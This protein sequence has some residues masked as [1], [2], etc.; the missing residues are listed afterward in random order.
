LTK[1]IS[2]AKNIK[3]RENRQLV[4]RLLRMIQTYFKDTKI[5]N[6]ILYA[7]I[8]EYNVEIFKTFTPEIKLKQFYYRCSNKFV[9][10]RFLHL[11][12]KVLGFIIFING[13]KCNIYKFDN[14]FIKLKSIN[15]NLIKKQRKGGQS[16]LRFS[17]LAKE[18]KHEYIIHVIDHINSLCRDQN[19][20]CYIFGSKELIKMILDRNE[21]LVKL[22]NGGFLN[23]NEDTINES[24]KWLNYLKQK[25]FDDKKLK[26]IVEYLDTNIDMLDFDENNK[27]MMKYYMYKKDL[28]KYTK[29]KYYERL[30]MF[31]YIG[32]KYFEYLIED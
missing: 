15:A 4:S 26:E 13:E 16:A 3:N 17:R 7:G 12:E 20:P 18:S 9:I 23:F 25:D 14:T 5:N 31:E 1:E 21:L 22:N 24:D 10:D 32:V 30:K 19:L 6:V 29:S 8:N 2:D 11:F 28:D 27:E